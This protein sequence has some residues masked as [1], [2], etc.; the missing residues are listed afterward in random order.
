MTTECQSEAVCPP[1]VEL[2][3]MRVELQNTNANMERI[4]GSIEK[5]TGDHE[6]RIRV[7]EVM[8]Q[9][10]AVIGTVLLAVWPIVAKKLGF[11]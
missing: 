1:V 10:L 3:R 4:A 5:V 9:R 11:M 6:K 7:L 2:A 8:Y